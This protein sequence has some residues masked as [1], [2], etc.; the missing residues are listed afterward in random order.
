[1]YEEMADDKAKSRAKDQINENLRRVYEEALNE[2]VP[3]RFKLLLDQLRAK[4][5][6]K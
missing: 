1:M 4:E 3:D 6:D 5:G 2:E